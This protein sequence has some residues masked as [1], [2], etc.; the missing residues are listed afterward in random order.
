MCIRDSACAAADRGIVVSTADAVCVRSVNITAGAMRKLGL[1][2]I[3]LVIKEPSVD[4]VKKAFNLGS[5]EDRAAAVKEFR[6]KL[7]G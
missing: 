7:K 3:R 1:S 5:E 6:D 4:L 2:D